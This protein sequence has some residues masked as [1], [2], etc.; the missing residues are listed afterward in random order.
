VAHYSVVVQLFC[1]G[2][3]MALIFI[4]LGGLLCYVVLRSGVS[5]NL[6]LTIAPALVNRLQRPTLRRPHQWII[7]G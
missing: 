2:G 6:G 3:Y 1:G 7:T 4:T 5:N